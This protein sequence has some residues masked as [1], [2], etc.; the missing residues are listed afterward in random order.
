MHKNFFEERIFKIDDSFSINFY[1]I[2]ENNY[3][4]FINEF[5]EFVLNNILEIYVTQLGMNT[6]EEFS[7]YIEIQKKNMY[8]EFKIDYKNKKY[9]INDNKMSE[10]FLHWLIKYEFNEEV[11][12]F[13]SSDCLRN[14]TKESRGGIDVVC[15][16][17]SLK[18][19]IIGESKFTENDWKVSF[20]ELKNQLIRR[21][22]H[23]DGYDTFGNLFS[24]FQTRYTKEIYSNEE[25]ICKEISDILEKIS[26]SLKNQNKINSFSICRGIVTKKINKNY[27]EEINNLIEKFEKYINKK[28][29]FIKNKIRNVDEN[30]EVKIYFLPKDNWGNKNE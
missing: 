23:D 1:F 5:D 7:K 24:N 25:N 26:E 8:K 6:R 22:S 17:K 20:R 13:W 14:R 28:R 18:K 30:I 4:D 3:N 10:F 19:I 9:L 29:D 11:V 21:I 2:A 27:T 15:Y 12:Q 16:N